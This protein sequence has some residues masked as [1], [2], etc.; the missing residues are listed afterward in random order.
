[1]TEW[2]SRPSGDPGRIHA[3]GLEARVAVEGAREEV[4]GLFGAR[5]RSVV[6][7]SSATEAIAAG[8]LGGGGARGPPGAGRRRALRGAARGRGGERGHRRRR[9]PHRAHRSRTSWSAPSGR[10][11]RSS[12][13]RPPTTRSAPCSPSP[14]WWRRA[15]TAVCSST[16]TPRRPPGTCRSRST[17]SAPTCCPCRPTSSAGRPASARCWCD[18]A[19]A[20][21]RCCGA[22]IRS[23]PAEPASNRSRRSPASV[24]RPR[25]F[26]PS[27][28]GRRPSSGASPT[29]CAT[30]WPTMDGITP[31]GIPTARLPHLVCVGV[32]GVEPQAV[33]LGLD[34]AGVAAHSGSSCSSESLEPSPV[35]EAMG[36][37]AHHS[38]RLSVG[39]ST[40]RGRH[41][42]RAHGPPQDPR[43]PP[44]LR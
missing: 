40:H 15:A 43:G 20:S 28:T 39:W 26:E 12:T 24:P 32:D 3:E 44:R 42:R 21:A 1:M 8:V 38:L 16:S 7:T 41:R 36:V 23:G 2:L 17:S 19:C 10:T 6:F 14:R 34:R 30:A 13:C 18:E 22:A 31:Y 11:R 27:S 4:A 33:L 9:R 37:D 25:R 5:P 35:L 29:A